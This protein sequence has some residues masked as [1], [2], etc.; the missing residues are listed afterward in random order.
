MQ[1]SIPLKVFGAI[2]VSLALVSFGTIASFGTISLENISLDDNQESWFVSIDIMMAIIFTPIGGK[3]T[4]FLG[5]K[6]TF[7]LFAPIIVLGWILVGT[8]VSTF[9][10]LLGRILCGIGIAILMPSPSVYIAETAHPNGRAT[11]SSII[12]LSYNFG[13]CI[14][15]FLGYFFEWQY[16][17]FL[18]TLPAVITFFGFLILP[19]TPYWLIQNQKFEEAY[20]SLKY[21]RKNDEEKEVENEYQE[22]LQSRQE[23]LN[24]GRLQ[25]ICSLTFFRPFLCIGI[26][27]PLQE[28]GGLIITTNYFQSIMIDSK[29]ELETKTCSLILGFVRIFSCLLT[30]AT[31]QKM[32]PKLT[33]I[34]F[35]AIKA[36]CFLITG[37]Y[38]LPKPY[39]LELATWTWIPFAMFVISYFSLPF[40]H[41]I[42]W[43]LTGEMYPSEVRNFAVGLTECLAYTADFVLLRIYLK[44]KHSIGL[45]GVF[46]MFAGISALCVIYAALTVPDNRGQSLSEIEK[47]Y[48]CK[49][50]LLSE[51]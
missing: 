42:I 34:G 24:Q 29:I 10:L 36:V 49:T 48:N 38:F 22:M 35:I 26:L 43:S 19:E 46:F 21:F 31:I 41:A 9:C 18:S 5:I 2:N 50:P 20:A 44:M 28:L 12:G 14:L 33:F 40:I 23:K 11:L 7:L 8:F 13:V 25:I 1:N 30:L 27:Y 45:Y 17:A 6:K 37:I 3:I 15:W 16:V 4:E 47:K 51:K 39:H 32:Q